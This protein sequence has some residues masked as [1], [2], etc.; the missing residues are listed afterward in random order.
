MRL[1]ATELAL[2]VGL[3]GCTDPAELTVRLTAVPAPAGAH[4]RVRVEAR[5][6]GN[7][8]PGETLVSARAVP[9]PTTKPIA[10]LGVPNGDDRIVIAEV[11]DGD[12]ADAPVLLY[13]LSQAFTVAPAIAGEIEVL[14]E[15][16]PPPVN[17]GV[18]IP[19]AANR[20][21]RSPLVRAHVFTN[22]AVRVDLSGSSEFALNATSSW[23]LSAVAPV[24]EAAPGTRGF[25]VDV[26]LD[27][28]HGEPCGGRDHC[29][30]SVFARFVDAFGYA[31]DPSQTSV[32]LDERAPRLRA[33]TVELR[34][35]PLATSPLAA[36]ERLGPQ[37]IAR[38]AAA[39]D[40]PVD[41]APQLTATSTAVSC[42][43][44]SGR[45]AAFVFHCVVAPM[46]STTA[47]V[48]FEIHAADQAGNELHRALPVPSVALDTTTPTLPQVEVAGAVVHH[49][50]P[51]GTDAAGGAPAFTVRGEPGAFEPNSTVIAYEQ[52]DAHPATELARGRVDE[53][54][55]LARL[56]V[57]RPVRGSLVVVSFDSAG[58]ASGAATVA[59]TVWTGSLAA[60]SRDP[61]VT[62]FAVRLQHRTDDTLHQ[63]G[64]SAEQ[65]ERL[66]SVDGLRVSAESRP[67]WVSS[68]AF[69]RPL[70]T[71]AAMALDP[72]RGKIV[73]QHGGATL[74]WD[75]YTWTRAQLRT[76]PVPRRDGHALIY[77]APWDR[78]IVFGGRIGVDAQND[79]WSFDGTSWVEHQPDGDRPAAR[80][81]HALA[82]DGAHGS[83][84]TFGGRGRRSQVLD[85]TWIFDG[86]RWR[87][88]DGPGPLGREGAAMA[89]DR[90]RER[91]V[92]FGGGD[93]PTSYGDTWLW[94]GHRWDRVDVPGPEARRGHA[95]V[96]DPR[97]G[98]TVLFGGQGVSEVL[99][100]T[101][102]WDGSTWQRV[103]G[104]TPPAR[105]DHAL[106][107][108]DVNRRILLWGGAESPGGA[109]RF[110]QWSFDGTRWLEDHEGASSF[111]RYELYFDRRLGQVVRLR[112]WVVD[113]WDGRR[114][115]SAPAAG[116][117]QESRQNPGIAYDEGRDR[118]LVFGG[119]R[120]NPAVESDELW[121]LD[122]TGWAR[123]TPAGPSP[124][125][126]VFP[127]MT[128]HRA[129]GR[130]VLFG[131]LTLVAGTIVFGDT[132]T[133]D[134]TRWTAHNPA[135]APRARW[136]A[137]IAEDERRGVVVL[138]GGDH[139]TGVLGDTWE[140]D[141]Q[142]W[143][144]RTPAIAPSP[145]HRGAMTWSPRLQRV[146]LLGGFGEDG[147][148]TDLWSWDGS[149]WQRH[150]TTGAPPLCRIRYVLTY[151]RI[152]DRLLSVGDDP[153]TATWA[154]S[155]GDAER[156]AVGISVDLT[157]AGVPLD[158]MRGGRVDVWAGGSPAGAQ[159]QAWDARLGRWAT[160]ARTPALATT[161]T[162][163]TGSWTSTAARRFA[164]GSGAIHLRVRAEAG[165]TA[166]QAPARVSVDYGEVR[167]QYRVAP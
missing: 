87:S 32:I 122:E 39:L 130:T 140:W 106:A 134:G 107:V 74:E 86:H 141:G 1:A 47:T 29:P 102:L 150:E 94:D 75:G 156:P 57:G 128:A 76:P 80:S 34:L 3:W 78:S 51:W 165:A 50:A 114:W 105:V 93:G 123:L 148:Y 83:I 35:L 59:D 160:W 2:L 64:A 33:D 24:D 147:R 17:G 85:D 142:T 11:V 7:D 149:G 45:V 37:G 19:S 121:A 164:L 166:D 97:L 62:P 18:N 152:R 58:N 36:I 61:G 161:P 26:D 73:M 110:D 101:W 91:V 125:G 108:D 56:D 136:G 38:I 127:A 112:D 100:D 23:L 31:S 162:V 131:G 52:L 49:R 90:M 71:R 4:V 41:A 118:L 120:S 155:F 79:L 98:R 27:R 154:L 21:V 8:V 145:R 6:L 103:D 15:L 30:R 13:G 53:V 66:D 124:A 126:R 95:M 65:A 135:T 116:G 139:G 157:L 48:G 77:F 111:G 54:G 119:R 81:E 25:A 43:V 69:A 129:A 113:V 55:G 146:V 144:E 84:V 63:G 88:A 70:A 143:T 82:Y 151:D 5:P 22:T 16:R 14:V 117:L 67:R 89:Y 163:L 40:E 158:R 137:Q 12:A 167:L 42:T 96:Y 153:D 138:F 109:W 72:A 92:L 99:A 46:A 28:L 60:L 132:W 20:W 159:L 115:Q 68:L 44:A 9:F 104:V 133:W 10:L